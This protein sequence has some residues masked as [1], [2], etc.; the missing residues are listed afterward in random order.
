MSLNDEGLR[1]IARMKELTRTQ[2]DRLSVLSDSVMM[3]DYDPARHQGEFIQQIATFL[4]KIHDIIKAG[5]V[6]V[7]APNASDML[8]PDLDPLFGVRDQQA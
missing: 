7:N 5:I 8:D 3:E 1:K 2:F 4:L 6:H